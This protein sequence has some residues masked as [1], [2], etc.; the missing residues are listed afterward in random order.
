[1]SLSSCV[2]VRLLCANIIEASNA[3]VRDEQVTISLSSRCSVPCVPHIRANGTPPK[4]IDLHAPAAK[5]IE[6]YSPRLVLQALYL[7][8]EPA[9]PCD[10][11][12]LSSASPFFSHL[13]ASVLQLLLPYPAALRI[14]RELPRS[15]NKYTTNST[16]VNTMVKAVVAGAAGGIGQVRA[17]M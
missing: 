9:A 12:S 13:T 4:P 3:P 6:R 2:F 11:F 1:M 16:Y 7:S 15:I 17:K 5:V 10:F 14:S 8:L